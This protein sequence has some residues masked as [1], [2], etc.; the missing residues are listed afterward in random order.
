MGRITDMLDSIDVSKENTEELYK[1][2]RLVPDFDIPVLRFYLYRGASLIRQR[3]NIKG[4][5]FSKVSDLSYPPAQCIKGYERANYPYQPMFYACCFPGDY[6]SDDVPPPRVVA[7]M[8]TSSFYRNISASGIERSTVS[9]WDLIKDLELVAMPFLADYS[10]AC[11]LI[12]EIK[13]GWND[14]CGQFEVNR[15]G[16][17]L[18]MYMASEIGKNFSS[19]VEYFKIANFVNYLLNI[20]EKTKNVDGIIYPSVPAAGAGFNVAIKPESFQNKVQFAGASKCYLAKK[21]DKAFQIVINQSV[22]VKDGII[23]YEN[24]GIDPREY[25]VY[26]QYAEGSDFIN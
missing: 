12:R 9:R 17:E 25:A 20:N 6:G 16:L 13:S 15:D 21:M 8:E 10:R 24:R 7:L 11:K 22:S 3:V 18:I 19:N 14:V 5:D 23:T 26:S 1:I 4:K 2:F